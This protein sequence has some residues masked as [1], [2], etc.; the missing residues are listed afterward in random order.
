MVGG[1]GMLR[2][3]LLCA[4]TLDVGA[5][6]GA[7][8]QH[9]ASDDANEVAFLIHAGTA[10]S[11][12]TASL[13]AHLDET[14]DEPATASV[15]PAPS[16]LIER[17][18]ASA[19]DRPELLWLEWRDCEPRQCPD[20]A[21][22]VARLQALDP[23]NGLA[24]LSE[25]RSAEHG[26]P[27]EVTRVLESMAD[28]PTPRLYWNQLAVMMFDALTHRDPGRPATAMTRAAD[29]RLIVVVGLMAAVDVPTFQRL[30]DACRADQFDQ[31]GRRA[32]CQALMTHLED[33]DA[34]IAQ[35]LSLV[36]QEGWWPSDSAEYAALHRRQLQQRYLA[37]A[38]NRFRNGHADRDAEL[39]VAAMRRAGRE[40]DAERTMMAVFH[41]PLLRPAGW[42]EPEAGR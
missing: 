22:I 28:R 2:C 41:E 12:A 18:V 13:L 1:L 24:W 14:S 26:S 5:A 29:D 34:A 19:P 23:D 21:Q 33:S 37:V 39:R 40:E 10:F 32:A 35:H 9:L 31:P 25:L 16:E 8:L 6:S 36:V 4:A 15:N 42:R 3:L 30:V 27:A 17:A 11:L 38:S 7:G 20:E